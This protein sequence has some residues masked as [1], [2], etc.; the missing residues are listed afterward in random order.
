MRSCVY[1]RTFGRH[2]TLRKKN[3]KFFLCWNLKRALSEQKG[4]SGS[5]TKIRNKKSYFE[6]LPK[7][8]PI[9]ISRSLLELFLYYIYWRLSKSAFGIPVVYLST[10]YFEYFDRSKIVFIAPSIMFLFLPSFQYSLKI[11]NIIKVRKAMFCLLVCF[12]FS[13]TRWIYFKKWREHQKS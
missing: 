6:D 3:T 2:M 11:G 7:I 10:L 1:F 5:I 4:S 13:L 9:D 8:F 12:T